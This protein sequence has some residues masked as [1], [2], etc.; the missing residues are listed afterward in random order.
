M[1]IDGQRGLPWYIRGP[2]LLTALERPEQ[3]NRVA[4]HTP[5]P[6]LESHGEHPCRQRVCDSGLLDRG[7]EVPAPG[8]R[9]G[10]GRSGG[11]GTLPQAVRF[12]DEVRS[13]GDD[14]DDQQQSE[15]ACGGVCTPFGRDGVVLN[16]FDGRS[17]SCGCLGSATCRRGG[18]GRPTR[19]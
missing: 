10:L 12:P 6:L 4:R 8:D 15:Y 1:C 17:G 2:V 5:E 14:V 16:L 3:P 13:N 19:S 11:G 7:Q 18:R 9:A